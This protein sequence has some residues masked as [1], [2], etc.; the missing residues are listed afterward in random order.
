VDE[1]KHVDFRLTFDVYSD[2]N[3]K[4]PDVLSTVWSEEIVDVSAVSSASGNLVSGV[5]SLPL[6]SLFPDPSMITLVVTVPA[7]VRLYELPGPILKTS[8]QVDVI[9][10][11]GYLVLTAPE[12]SNYI[13]IEATQDGSF[14]LV[15]FGK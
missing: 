3:L 8:V 14:S 1:M 7:L 13:E 4:S 9:G 15:V 5:V 2:G 12:Y 10:N 11:F 6:S